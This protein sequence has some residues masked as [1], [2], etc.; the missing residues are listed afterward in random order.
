MLQSLS[1]V[2]LNMASMLVTLLTVKAS[3]LS[4]EVAPKS[5][6][7]MSVTRLVA[8]RSGWLKEVAA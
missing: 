1:E 6:V 4:K 8:K 2:P 5:M 7:P 3:G